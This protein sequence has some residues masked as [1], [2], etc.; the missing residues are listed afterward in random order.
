MKFWQH[1]F[2]SFFSISFYAPPYFFDIPKI[3]NPLDYVFGV[4]F[5]VNFS[6]I[7]VPEKA[8]SEFHSDIIT[9]F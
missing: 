5:G 6:W 4:L 2:N 8:L 1:L 3:H 7:G 9:P